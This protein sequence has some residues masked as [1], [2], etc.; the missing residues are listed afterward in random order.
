MNKEMVLGMV[1]HLL[2]V[3]S[4]AVIANGS[5]SLESAISNLFKNISTGD[6]S[7]ITSTVVLIASLLWSMWAKASEQTKTNVVKTLTFQK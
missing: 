4:G 2:T 6:P 3:V 1:R 7:A 5:D